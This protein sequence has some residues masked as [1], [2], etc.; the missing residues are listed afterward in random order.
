MYFLGSSFFLSKFAML[1]VSFKSYMLNS[2]EDLFILINFKIMKKS[3]LTLATFLVATAGFSQ[4]T[5]SLLPVNRLAE[6][7]K[8]IP[9]SMLM[10][11]DEKLR[12]NAPRKAEGDTLYYLRPEGTY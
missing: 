9:A 4:V 7:E 3:L 1:I 12:G 11:S 10:T 2:I 8:Q 6:T 5:K